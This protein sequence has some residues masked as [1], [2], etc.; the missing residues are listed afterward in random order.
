MPDP[1]DGLARLM[2]RLKP[3]SVR[4]PQPEEAW[5]PPEF[6]R[7]EDIRAWLKE[8]VLTATLYERYPDGRWTMELLLKEQVPGKVRRLVL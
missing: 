3:G 4:R 8:S 5:T 6:E 1:E 2:E 7:Y